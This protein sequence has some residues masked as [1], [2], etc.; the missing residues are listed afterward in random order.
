[1]GGRAV[2]LIRGEPPTWLAGSGDGYGSGSGYGSGDGFLSSP[3]RAYK[4]LIGADGILLSPHTRSMFPVAIGGDWTPDVAPQLCDAGWHAVGP[5][6]LAKWLTSYKDKGP[7]VVCEVECMGA[8]VFGDD[9]LACERMR[10]V[11]ELTDDEV[12]ELCRA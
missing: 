5:G 10:I 3:L 7:L 9:K 8:V 2:G 12:K 11:R 6:S 4:V 1:M